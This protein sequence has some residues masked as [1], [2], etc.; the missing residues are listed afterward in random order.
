MFVTAV[1]RAVPTAAAVASPAAEIIDVNWLSAEL[2]FV[3][4]VLAVVCAVEAFVIAVPALVDAVLAVDVTL[5]AAVFSADKV[6]PVPDPP[7]N[8][9]H[10]S[11]SVD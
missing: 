10:R 2:A 4:A 11:S 7:V 8:A 3:P 1:L 5:D 6:L 9:C